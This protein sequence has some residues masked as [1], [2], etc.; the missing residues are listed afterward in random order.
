MYTTKN[1]NLFGS[2]Y[3]AYRK[4]KSPQVSI[5][6]SPHLFDFAL[7]KLSLN[8]HGFTDHARILDATRCRLLNTPRAFLSF[9][10]PKHHVHFVHN[11]LQF[12]FPIP[13]PKLA[14][15]HSTSYPTTHMNRRQTLIL[16]FLSSLIINAPPPAHTRF[17]DTLVLF[18]MSVCRETNK[19]STPPIPNPQSHS[20]NF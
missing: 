19:A 17:S 4:K 2:V 11:R 6:F 8:G 3:G 16:Q 13:C 9:V 7:E 10:C 12:H 15:L 5:V 1:K 14:A 18:S 20:C